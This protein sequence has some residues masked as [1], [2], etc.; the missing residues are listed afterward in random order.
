[1]GLTKEKE[2]KNKV[3]KAEMNRMKKQCFPNERRH[4]LNNKVSTD[5]FSED[6]ISENTA[7]FYQFTNNEHQISINYE[8]INRERNNKLLNQYSDLV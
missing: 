1:M 5:I 8:I 2:L 6:V 3:L 4:F 7:G